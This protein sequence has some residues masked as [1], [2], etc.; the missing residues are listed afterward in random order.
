MINLIKQYYYIKKYD[1]LSNDTTNLLFLKACITFGDHDDEK[2]LIDLKFD[3][4]N[5]RNYSIE[6]IT[7]LIDFY[8]K[9]GDII[10]AFNI[11]KN[12]SSNNK[13]DIG[14]VTAMMNAYNSNEQ[15]DKT[16]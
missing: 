12:G 10:N 6:F 9:S 13:S 15:Y 5:I 8:G 7:T 14:C 3:L 16:R 2:K 1:R 11:F 4:K